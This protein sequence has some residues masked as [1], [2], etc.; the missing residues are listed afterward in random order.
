[1]SQQNQPALE[2]AWQT[3]RANLEWAGQFSLI[4]VFC[5][6]SRAKEALFRRADDLM[7]TQVRPF[8]RIPV[9]EATD[10]KIR[11]LPAAVNPAVSSV[12][13]GMPLW[14]DLDGHPTDPN[15][16]SART[17]F[18]YRLNERRASMVREHTRA[19]VLALPL[20]WT[21]QAAEAAP[22]LWTIRQPSVYLETTAAGL[23]V[24][25]EDGDKQAKLATFNYEQARALPPKVLRWQEGVNKGEAFTVWDAAQASDAALEG[26]HTVIAVDIAR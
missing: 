14:L 24:S 17:E 10:F 15:W 4:F 18:L 3:L 2:S 9:R 19:V 22:D 26:G 12:K 25:A 23:V 1:M 6:D 21:K 11:L 8:E 16:D 13:I 5:S 7:R 20:D